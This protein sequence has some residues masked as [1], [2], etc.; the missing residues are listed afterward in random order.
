MWWSCQ[1]VSNWLLT[2]LDSV[3]FYKQFE[4]THPSHTWHAASEWQ[5]QEKPKF[6]QEVKYCS[7]YVTTSCQL[8][9]Y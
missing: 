3:F 8:V 6:K 5:E 7:R 4:K 9:V 1:L 2:S